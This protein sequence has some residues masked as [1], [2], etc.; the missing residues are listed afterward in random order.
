MQAFGELLGFVRVT[1]SA[2][3]GRQFVR[4]REFF[5]INVGVAA[6][7]FERCVRRRAQ[8]GGIESGRNAS[9]SFAGPSA[10]IVAIDAFRRTWQFFRRLRG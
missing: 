6:I 9:L 3:D 10:L 5:G 7:A 1:R 4:V 8:G 2:I